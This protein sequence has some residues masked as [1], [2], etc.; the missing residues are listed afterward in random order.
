ME[1]R[2]GGLMKLHPLLSFL[3]EAGES[4]FFTE[5]A[6]LGCPCSRGWPCAYAHVENIELN[7]LRKEN[8]KLAWDMARG[9]WGE[10]EGLEMDMIKLYCVHS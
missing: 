3:L 6:L 4:V 9:V 2:W 7:G 1:F 10:L 8:P 5:M